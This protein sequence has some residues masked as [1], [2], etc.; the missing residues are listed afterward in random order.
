MVSEKGKIVIRVLKLMF[1]YVYCNPILIEII[2]NVFLSLG[3]RAP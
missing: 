3:I 1:P 2:E